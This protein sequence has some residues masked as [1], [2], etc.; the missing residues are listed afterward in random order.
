MVVL[1]HCLH[2]R[3]RHR[4]RRRLLV[5]LM[6]ILLMM[7]MIP[8]NTLTSVVNSSRTCLSAGRTNPRPKRVE[9][10]VTDKSPDTEN[11]IPI[12]AAV[13]IAMAATPV[14]PAGGILGSKGPSP[15]HREGV[16]IIIIITTTTN[17]TIITIMA[18]MMRVPPV[19]TRI[20]KIGQPPLSCYIWQPSYIRRSR[21]IVDKCCRVICKPRCAVGKMKFQSGLLG[22]CCLGLNGP[23]GKQTVIVSVFRVSFDKGFS[24]P[25]LP[26]LNLSQ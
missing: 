10:N 5:C 7:V 24:R 4:R 23:L 13:M 8:A 17:V 25:V 11:P 22:D 20:R 18:T 19:G 6:M 15:S 21:R 16:A 9:R 1:V 2:L 3:R 14:A 26:S 12:A